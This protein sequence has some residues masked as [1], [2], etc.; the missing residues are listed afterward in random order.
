[1]IQVKWMIIFERIQNARKIRCE[2][3]K[4]SKFCM[5]L[6]EIKLYLHT[7]NKAYTSV[8]MYLHTKF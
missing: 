7:Y 2:K 3:C 4:I 6:Y 1:M 5:I 8:Q